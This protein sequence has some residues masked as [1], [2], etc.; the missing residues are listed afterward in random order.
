M[1]TMVEVSVARQA[2]DEL[3]DAFRRLV[4]QL[5][6]SAAP[7]DRETLDATLRSPSNTV[8]IAR[9]GGEIVGMLTLVMYRVTTGLRAR[10]EDVVVDTRTR[11]RGVGEALT[12]EALDRASQAGARSVDLT[13]NPERA[14]ANRLYQRMGFELRE[15]NAYRYRFK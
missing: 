8:L 1:I 5:S 6:S 4:P 15:T 7:I 12:R 13:S 2:S 11:G 14:A 10:I 9:D 3:L